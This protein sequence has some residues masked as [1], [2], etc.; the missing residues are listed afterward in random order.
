MLLIRKKKMPTKRVR[1]K[2]SVYTRNSMDFVTMFTVTENRNS[3]VIQ[4]VCSI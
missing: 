1:V 2:Y 3:T 4:V